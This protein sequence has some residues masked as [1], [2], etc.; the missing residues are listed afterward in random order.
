[1]VGQCPETCLLPVG[2]LGGVGVKSRDDI[3][4]FLNRSIIILD[5]HYEH[6]LQFILIDPLI[7]VIVFDTCEYPRNLV[8]I[9]GSSMIV[10]HELVSLEPINHVR[11]SPIFTALSTI[12]FMSN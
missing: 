6:M 4:F 7:I 9:Q 8:T 2:I 1:M 3:V 11:L 10:R 5:L 12:Y